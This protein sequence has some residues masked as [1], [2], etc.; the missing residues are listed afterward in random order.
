MAFLA[1][2]V[3]L[4]LL[5]AACASTEVDFKPIGTVTRIDVYNAVGTFKPE[6]LHDPRKIARLV[7]IM[8]RN[9]LGW[10]P[11]RRQTFGG[12]PEEKCAYGVGFYRNDMW[13]AGVSLGSDGATI[14]RAQTQFSRLTAFKTDPEMVRSMLAILGKRL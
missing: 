9:R 7:E 1:A 2:V 11:E 4:P 6:S 13:I 8:N 5:L 12:G 14:S 10:T 3:L